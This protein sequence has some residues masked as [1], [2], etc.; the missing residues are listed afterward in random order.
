MAAVLESLFVEEEKKLIFDEHQANVK[1]ISIILTQYDDMFSRFIRMMLHQEYT[2]VSLGME[3]Y[4]TAF[5]FNF[6]G[7]A[8]EKPHKLFRRNKNKSIVFEI[9]NDQYERMEDQILKFQKQKE[10][11]NYT[12]LGVLLC[13]LRIPFVRKRKYF[14]SHFVAE[15]LYHG[16]FALK[17]KHQFYLP[18]H[19]Y[20]ELS[21]NK[22]VYE[23]IS[24]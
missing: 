19:L 18:Q 14:C 10:E 22:Y 20:H 4:E 11:L 23:I 2:H 8:L 12:K 6:K 7:F 24:H 5:S 17:K 13:V 1:H 15:I 3:G 16:G 21:D 9:S